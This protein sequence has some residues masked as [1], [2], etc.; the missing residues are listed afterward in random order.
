M[1]RHPRSYF[2]TSFFHIMVQGIAKDFIFNNNEFKK[3]YIYYLKQYP[4]VNIME[5][6]TPFSP[7]H[8]KNSKSIF[9][10]S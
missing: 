5:K 3:E 1:P 4:F 9:C 6:G 2:E 8:W 7:S 10:G